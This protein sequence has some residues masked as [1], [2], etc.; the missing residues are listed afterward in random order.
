MDGSR[1]NARVPDRDSKSSPAMNRARIRRGT[2]CDVRRHEH[3]TMHLTK[4]VEHLNEA[5]RWHETAKR[6][7]I[8]ANRRS[9]GGTS[10]SRAARIS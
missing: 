10:A 8:T 5:N 6:G 9:H 4:A 3:I 1:G 7:Q 2:I